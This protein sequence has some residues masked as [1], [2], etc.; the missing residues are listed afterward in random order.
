MSARA[1]SATEARF[2][3]LLVDAAMTMAEVETFLVAIRDGD[4]PADDDGIDAML[5]LIYETQS[6]M[7]AQHTEVPHG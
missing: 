4:L 7:G 2:A 5:A 1:M 3:S 6:K